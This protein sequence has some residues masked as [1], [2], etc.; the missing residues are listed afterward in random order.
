MTFENLTDTEQELVGRLPKPPVSGTVRTTNVWIV[1]WLDDQIDRRTGFELHERLETWRP[2]WSLYHRCSSAHEVISSIERATAVAQERGMVPVLHLEAHGGNDGL[3]G[4]GGSGGE[5]LITWDELT[6]PLQQLNL[7]THCNLVVFVAACVGFAGI[8]ALRR[9]PRAPA[10]MLIGPDKKLLPRDLLEGTLEL[11]RQWRDGGQHIQDIVDT[12]NREV[13]DADFY[14][15]PFVSIA[16]DALVEQLII[17]MRPQELQHRT[18]LMRERLSV[19]TKLTAEQIEERLGMLPQV[20][21]M[22]GQQT[23]DEMFMLDLYPENRERFELDLRTVCD[24]I[25]GHE[26]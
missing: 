3:A 19:E 24:Q 22:G 11:Y 20:E 7:A 9:G 16:Y 2:G 15:E 17:R 10:Y 12:A 25:L 13:V 1:E 4:P 23:W 6:E 5:E 14:W 21:A 18:D 8:Q 26:D